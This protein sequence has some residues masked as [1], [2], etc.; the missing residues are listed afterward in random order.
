[1]VLF[2]TSLLSILDIRELT[3]VSSIF[4]SK[5]ARVMETDTIVIVIYYIIA[6]ASILL[7]KWVNR[8]F[9]PSVNRR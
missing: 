8:R 3:Q 7:L 6:I 4:N 2:G 9:F 5:N 1:M